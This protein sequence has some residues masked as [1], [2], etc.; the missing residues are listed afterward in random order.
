[1]TK[2]QRAEYE[3]WLASLQKPVPKFARQQH[4]PPSKTLEYK[5]TT[6][7]GR[8]VAVG[9]SLVTSGSSTAQKPAQAYTGDKMLGLGQLHKSNM[10]PVFKAEDAIDIARMRRN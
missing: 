3:K 6:P 1:M 4:E 5:L 9:K 7:P 10:V 2:K 8:N